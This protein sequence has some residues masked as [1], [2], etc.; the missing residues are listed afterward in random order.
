VTASTIP[1]DPF[2]FTQ[3][4]LEALPFSEAEYSVRDTEQPGLICRLFPPGK[5]YPDGLKMLQVYRK[6]KGGAS[7]VRV[8][9]CKLGELPM[10]ALKGTPSVRSTVDEIL[11][12][13]REGVN[14]NE[15]T[16]QRQA[17]ERA[18]AKADKVSDTTLGQAF[19][20]YVEIKRLRPTTLKAYRLA[21]DRD[22][23][24]WKDKPLR[25]I[26]GA[27]AV[28]RHAKIA[29]ISS[30]TAMRAMQVL[31]LTHHFATDFF[32]DDFNDAPFGRCPVDKVNRVQRQWS[33]TTARTDKLRLEDLAPW[34]ASV[35]RLAEE[36]RRGDGKRMGLYLELVLL[37]GLRRREA[38]F[39][40]WADV[41]FRRGT[42]TVRE[43]KNHRDH[44]LPMT[45]RVRDILLDR[46]RT[47]DEED[48]ERAKTD[49]EHKPTEHVFGSAETRWQLYRIERETGIHASPHALRRSWAIFA[50]KAGL[51]AY[52][53]KA[54]LNHIT[55]GDVTGTHYAQIDTDDLRPLM[56]R[57]EDFILRHAEQRTDNVVEL[58]AGGR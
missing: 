54:A 23:G 13:L 53:I 57:V 21:V 33:R 56:Q 47:V 42:L 26:T 25:E 46:K 4:R 36:Q 12:Q 28:T 15:A 50:E 8:R 7:P 2:K 27:M 40:R 39:M 37:T 20:K 43:T 19:E 38:G 51:G 18:Q 31:R 48:R 24:D 49:K 9:I 55:T 1:Q 10:T 14:P 3:A 22:L 30:S 52:A 44:T 16:R 41:D 34:L 11:A 6:P 32:G 5:K 17:E 58:H 45:R 29:K 35:R